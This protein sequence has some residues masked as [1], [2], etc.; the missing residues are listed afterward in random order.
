ME[1]ITNIDK[2]DYIE[3]CKKIVANEIQED[4]SDELLTVVTSE[5]MDTC[6]AIG[7]DFAK[8]NIINITKQYVASGALNRIKWA[9]GGLK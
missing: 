8:D 7:G 2:T 9:H 1:C 6:L 5:I 4:M 3:E